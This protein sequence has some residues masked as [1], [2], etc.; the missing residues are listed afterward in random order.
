MKIEINFTRKAI[1]E[2]IAIAKEII[3]RKGK[4]MWKII[5]TTISNLV[6]KVKE[7][8]NELYNKVLRK[9]AVK[10]ELKADK[11]WAKSNDFFI[12]VNNRLG[13]VPDIQANDASNIDD[14]LVDV[15][16]IEEDSMVSI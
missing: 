12:K 8:L 13:I 6:V 9:R 14:E 11:L 7:T 10:L 4:E 5:K 16:D 2:K 1:K 15:V 3:I